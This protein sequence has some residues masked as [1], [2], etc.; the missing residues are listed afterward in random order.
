MTLPV[1]NRIYSVSYHILVNLHLYNADDL[2]E[3]EEVSN[4]I[5]SSALAASSS[6]YSYRTLPTNVCATAG[7]ASNAT[8]TTATSGG[9]GAAASSSRSSTANA[10]PAMTAQAS[11]EGALLGLAGLAI[12]AL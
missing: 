6:T 2:E 12:L 8:A 5:C 9:L 1:A 7:T 10:A 3:A 4:G 11:Y